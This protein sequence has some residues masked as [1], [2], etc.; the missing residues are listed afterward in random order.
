MG[1]RLVSPEL[2]GES[3]GTRCRSALRLAERRRGFRAPRAAGGGRASV[4]P[5]PAVSAP[6]DRGQRSA[7]RG[8]RGGAIDHHFGHPELSPSLGGGA[9]SSARS[10]ARP[11]SASTLTLL[12]AVFAACTVEMV[13]A[14]TIVAAGGGPCRWRSRSHG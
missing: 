14:L 10:G 6:S 12:L 11:V 7:Y 3:P 4:G 8:R 5:P 1:D 13:E 9:P 2:A